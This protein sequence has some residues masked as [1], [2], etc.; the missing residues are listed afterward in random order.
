MIIAATQNTHKLKEINDILSQFNIT[1]VSVNEAGLSEVTVI[2]DK[3]TFEG[4]SMK[5]A[6]TIMQI[7]E[8]PAIADDS[9]LSVHALNGRPGVYSARYAGEDA[10]DK[11]NNQKLLKEMEGI[12]DRRA[13][14]VSVISMAFPDGR[15]ISVRG[16]CHGRIEYEEKGKHGF[17]YDPLFIVNDYNKTFGELDHHI[18]NKISHRADALAKLRKKLD[19]IAIKD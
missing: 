7:S 9:G 16:E 11:E 2:E 1:V 13:K 18:K 17:G 15:R 5:K 6:E 8:K 12:E 3:D 14:F 4:N 19:K 10:T